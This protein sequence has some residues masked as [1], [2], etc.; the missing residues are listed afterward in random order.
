[1]NAEEIKKAIKNNSNYWE[2]RALENKLNI[3]ENEEDYVRRISAIYDQANKDIDDK[4]AKVYA[5]YAKENKLTLEQAYQIL[6]KKMETEYKKDVMDYVDKAKSGDP[7][8]QQYLLNQS[9]MHKHSVLDQLRTEFRN[10]I[11]NIDMETTGGK[12]LEKIYAN[13]NYYAQYTNNEEAFAKVDQDK[14]K[15]LL[16]EDWSGG[17]NF[18]Q[19]IWK[20]KEQLVQA[21]DDIV[22]RGLAVGESYDKMADKLSKRMDTSKSNARRLIMTESARMD[23]EGLLSYYKETDVKNL[24]FVAT[25]DMRTSDICKAMDGEIIPIDKAQIG[26]NVPPM[27]PYCRS[28]ISPY[29]ED[30]EPSTRMYRDK[31]TGKSTK[32]DYKNYVDY[33]ERHLGDKKQAKALASTKNDLATLI[34]AINSTV[35]IITPTENN[36]P[37]TDEEFEKV[38]MDVKN[39]ENELRAIEISHG[40]YNGLSESEVY[41]ELAKRYG[42]NKLPQELSKE[43]FD[44]IDSKV[45]YRGLSGEDLLVAKYI[46]G[47][48]KG[49]LYAGNGIY[50]FGTYFSYDK[51]L[52]GYYTYSGNQLDDTLIKD[53]N[54]IEVKL[55]PGAKIID[56]EDLEKLFIKYIKSGKYKLDP[57]NDI[58]TFAIKEGYDAVFVK[59]N[60]KPVTNKEFKKLGYTPGFYVANKYDYLNVLN[61]GALIYARRN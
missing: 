44:A 11:Y 18:S 36:I 23:N 14:I 47:F 53:T 6:P 15:R 17:G 51:S 21:L 45:L 5:R 52:A 41:R 13:A 30:N 48:Y 54:L 4:L 55:K 19:N 1:M 57:Y 33:L 49:N 37:K 20:N 35:N 7:K 16:E 29:Y 58:T 8:W 56:Y 39:Y 10:V 25:L 12:F 34:M 46:D 61:R 43:E 32:G 26:L 28:V 24:I 3:I 50:G 9:I 42:Y 2:K 22:I 60:T 27:H 59:E 40:N 31:D 38:V